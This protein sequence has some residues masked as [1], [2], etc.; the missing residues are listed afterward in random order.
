MLY[1]VEFG[2]DSLVT[3]LPI[4]FSIYWGLVVGFGGWFLLEWFD[5]NNNVPV[6]IHT[7]IQ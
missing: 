7:R 3:I 6:Y 5:Y 1:V 4:I 2:L